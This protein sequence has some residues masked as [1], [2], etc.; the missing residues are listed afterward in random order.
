MI[1]QNYIS[2]MANVIKNYSDEEFVI[3][4]VGVLG[5][6]NIPDLDYHVLLKEYDLLTYIKGK[7]IPGEFKLHN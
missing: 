1:L 2:D 5:N 7:L 4:C 6:M 3:E